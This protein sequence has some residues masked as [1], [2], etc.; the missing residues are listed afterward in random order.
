MSFVH[1]LQQRLIEVKEAAAKAAIDSGLIATAEVAADRLDICHECPRLFKPTG[2]CK[3]CGCFVKTKTLV[4][5][6]SCPL[7]KW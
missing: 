2:S 6:A 3:E 5:S 4:A 1:K 7:G